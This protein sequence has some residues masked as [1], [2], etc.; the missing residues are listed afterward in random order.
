MTTFRDF[1]KTLATTHISYFSLP[2]LQEAAKE[3]LN[4]PVQVETVSVDWKDIEG[5]AQGFTEAL[6]SLGIS[7]IPHPDYEGSDMYGFILSNRPLTEDEVKEQCI[8]RD[9]D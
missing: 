4:A 5:L 1:V 2:K 6:A 9:E 3:L 8:D 7:V